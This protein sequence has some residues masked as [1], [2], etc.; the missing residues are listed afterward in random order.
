M[1]N[2]GKLVGIF[3]AFV[4]FMGAIAYGQSS[5]PTRER[6]AV[7]VLNACIVMAMAAGFALGLI[8]TMESSKGDDSPTQEP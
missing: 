3:L 8:V 6:V 1:S 4:V 2:D 7:H 5:P